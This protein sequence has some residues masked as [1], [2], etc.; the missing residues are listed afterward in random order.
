MFLE[1]YYKLFYFSSMASFV[2]V[3]KVQ[4]LEE[5][6]E[7]APKG[8]SPIRSKGFIETDSEGSSPCEKF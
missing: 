3:R 8:G 5:D 6:K 4:T 7:N 2:T 1:Y